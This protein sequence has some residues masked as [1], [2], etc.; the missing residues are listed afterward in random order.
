MG[1]LPSLRSDQGTP[2]LRPGS[3]R[4]RPQ[5]VSKGVGDATRAPS[6]SSRQGR[7][8]YPWGTE[9]TTTTGGNITASIQA[10][11]DESTI[12]G[13]SVVGIFPHGAAAC[14]AE[15]LAGNVWEWCSTPKLKYPF[16]GEVSVES[17]YTG[18]KRVSGRYVLRGG[19]WGRYRVYARCAYRLATTPDV[20]TG[21]YG[22]RL[23]RLFSL[24]SS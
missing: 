23:A 10:N 13:T 12:G 5:A 9:L 14:G 1:A 24:S 16:E 8:E 21:N 6:T 11:I 22:F 18:N 20:V 15:E 4:G 7:R 3:G 17:L 19:S 2:S